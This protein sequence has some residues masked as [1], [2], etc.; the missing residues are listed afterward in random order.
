MPARAAQISVAGSPA[1]SSPLSSGKGKG[2]AKADGQDAIDPESFRLVSS[3]VLPGE[4]GRPNNLEWSHG[5][6]AL[7][8]TRE[9]L[10]ILTPCLGVHPNLSASKKL[11]NAE[12]LPHLQD[13]G[14]LL[15]GQIDFKTFSDSDTI[16]RTRHLVDRDYSVIHPTAFEAGWRQASWSPPTLGPSASSL[17]LAVTSDFDVCVFCARDNPFQDDWQM[18]HPLDMQPFQAQAEKEFAALLA[19]P[20]SNSRFPNDIALLRASNLATEGLTA[21]WSDALPTGLHVP[22]NPSALIAVGTRSGHVAFWE[23]CH[24][25]APGSVYRTS[26]RVS[27]NEVHRVMFGPWSNASDGSYIA[28]AAVQTSDRICICQVQCAEEVVTASQSTLQPEAHGVRLVTSMG[29]IGHFLI[30]AMTGEV[31]VFDTSSGRLTIHTLGEGN[32][33][34]DPLL[35]AISIQSHGQ[36]LA[37]VILQDFTEYRIALEDA[38]TRGPGQGVLCVEPLPKSQVNGYVPELEESQRQMDS[39]HLINGH[40]FETSAQGSTQGSDG[41]LGLVRT[42]DSVASFGFNLSS[43]IRFTLLMPIPKA[44]ST[45]AKQLAETC[46]DQA[47][48]RTDSDRIGETSLVAVRHVLALYLISPSRDMFVDGIWRVYEKYHELSRKALVAAEE[49]ERAQAASQ[50]RFAHFVARWLVVHGDTERISRLVPKPD[51]VKAHLFAVHLERSL[52]FLISNSEAHH[53]G[54]TGLAAADRRLCLNFAAATYQLGRQDSASQRMMPKVQELLSQ[55]GLVPVDI[56][57]LWE[58]TSEQEGVIGTEERCAACRSHLT[59]Q[60]DSSRGMVAWARCEIGH[61]WP[62]CVITMTPIVTPDALACVGCWAKAYSSSTSDESLGPLSRSLLDNNPRC[63]E[64]SN[65]WVKP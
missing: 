59:L 62:R 12:R 35:P 65:A 45:A 1:I 39:I 6:Q 14:N 18:V 53:L 56:M 43:S 22:P 29:F 28:Q 57:A 42:N 52:A 36:S 37:K 25:P 19:A 32:G 50:C 61:T 40:A 51:D 46:L 54:T 13:H 27:P 15:C 3:A 20:Q 9:A 11:A 16:Q 47:L 58:K 2:K 7:V 23:Y 4:S 63:W 34:T 49:T 10:F 64:C 5:G 8:T 30:Y 55:L 60:L 41:L 44:P 31:R 17:I 33:E 38:E 26:L 24:V 21:V 48:T